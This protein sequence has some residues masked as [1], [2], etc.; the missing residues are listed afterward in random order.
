ML[1]PNARAPKERIFSIYGGQTKNW[2]IGEKPFLLDTNFNT[3]PPIVEYVGEVGTKYIHVFSGV[4]CFCSI[5]ESHCHVDAFLVVCSF[6]LG[7]QV[8]VFPG[9]TG[10]E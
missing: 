2:K 6:A 7:E 9:N 4:C 1:S 5:R 3:G 10:V 8:N